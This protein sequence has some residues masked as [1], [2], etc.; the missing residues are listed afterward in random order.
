MYGRI[1]PIMQK[2]GNVVVVNPST[3]HPGV[4]SEQGML[5]T[6]FEFEL[7]LNFSWFDSLPGRRSIDLNL[8]CQDHGINEFLRW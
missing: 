7:S 6:D 1:P 3:D 4:S 5:P 8:V 2:S